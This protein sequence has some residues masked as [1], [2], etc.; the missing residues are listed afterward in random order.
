MLK[1]NIEAEK[2]L[3]LKSKV[4]FIRSIAVKFGFGIHPTAKA[5]GFLPNLT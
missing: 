2:L 4:C 5:V 1:N 3:A